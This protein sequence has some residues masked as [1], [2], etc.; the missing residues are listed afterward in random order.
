MRR[1]KPKADRLALLEPLAGALFFTTTTTILI[2]TISLVLVN[3]ID[4]EHTVYAIL[5]ISEFMS[6]SS[7]L[8]GPLSVDLLAVNPYIVPFPTYAVL[9]LDYTHSNYLTRRIV[10]FNS[11]RCRTRIPIRPTQPTLLAWPQATHHQ[12]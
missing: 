7:Q 1:S 4:G 11:P 2:L 5:A 10:L 6:Y 8:Q 9:L 12:A 3:A